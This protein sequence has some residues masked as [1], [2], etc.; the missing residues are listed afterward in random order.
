FAGMEAMYSF[1]PSIRLRGAAGIEI[2]QASVV[3][4]GMFDLLGRPAQ[5]GRTFA[6]GETRGVVVIS[7]AYW[8][9]RFGGDPGVIGR[10]IPIVDQVP[11]LASNA[12]PAPATVIGVMPADFVFP[13]RTMLG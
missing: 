5:L 4:P 8:Q 10:T 6:P 13:Y 3:T 7:H 1:L 2:T 12:T 11:P 9:R